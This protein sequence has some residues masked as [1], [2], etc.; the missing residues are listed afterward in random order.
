MLDIYLAEI[1][2]SEHVLATAIAVLVIPKDSK[3]TAK[4]AV[5]ILL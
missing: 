2:K 4:K 1:G 5:A 3:A